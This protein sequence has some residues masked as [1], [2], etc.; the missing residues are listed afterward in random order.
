LIH[1]ER[2]GA[3]SIADAPIED[4]LHPRR[5]LETLRLVLTVNFH[6]PSCEFTFNVGVDLLF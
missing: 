1:P 2:L 4:V 3:L 6:Q 5:P